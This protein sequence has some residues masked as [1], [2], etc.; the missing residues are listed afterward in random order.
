[1]VKSGL[2]EV[3]V[4]PRMDMVVSGGVEMS[5]KLDDNGTIN[6]NEIRPI[7]GYKFIS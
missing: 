5:G 2:C 4:D 3:K 1:M 6:V 7:E